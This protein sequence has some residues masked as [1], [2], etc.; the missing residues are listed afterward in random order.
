MESLSKSAVSWFS[1]R[2][3]GRVI[4]VLTLAS[5]MAE[6]PGTPVMETPDPLALSCSRSSSSSSSISRPPPSPSASPS[7]L[8]PSVNRLWRPAAQR[9]LRNQWS[10][11]ASLRQQW[12]SSSSSGKSH[13]NSLVNAYLSQRYSTFL[14]SF[15]MAYVYNFIGDF[16]CLL[17][18]GPI[19]SFSKVV[20]G[21]GCHPPFG[22]WEKKIGKEDNF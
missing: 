8:P 17:C 6:Q 9:N 2:P 11:L 21:F 16:F 10:K 7:P 22:C 14:F 3:L 12:V 19:V 1:R 4:C 20:L 13:A 5:S 18:C 15:C